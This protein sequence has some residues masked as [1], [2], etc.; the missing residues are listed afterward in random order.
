MKP[1]SIIFLVLSLLL[2]AGGVITCSVARDIA[3]TDNYPLFSESEDG[4]SF[5]RHTFDAGSI[6]K[7]ELLVSDAE[8]N[9]I[10]GADECAIELHNFQEG[11]YAFSTSA[12]VVSFDEIPD[13]KSLFSFRSGFSFSGLRYYLRPGSSLNKTKRI[14]LY[15]TADSALRILNIE[16][17]RCAVTADKVLAQFDISVKAAKEADL[18]LTD[19]RTA[20]AL[21]VSTKQLSMELSSCYVHAF[22]VTAADASLEAGELYFDD[23]TLNVQSGS[24]HI[25]ST[26]G[27]A[28]YGY[29][30]HGS[31]KFILAGVEK[32][33]PFSSDPPGTNTVVISGNIGQSE[34]RLDEIV[35]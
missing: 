14:D 17:D 10:G 11:L 29:D 3:L 34:L 19:Y 32:P 4:E 22:S 25:L 31:G 5:S 9:I 18:K 30:L 15:L 16:G 27:L 6:S 1:T 8:I 12:S 21:S 33:L 7:I 24:L 26:A 20:C 28:R 23:M 35:D 2:I 13:L